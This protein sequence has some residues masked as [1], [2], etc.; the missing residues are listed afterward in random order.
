VRITV[1]S[2]LLTLTAFAAGAE[3]AAR[4]LGC[5]A[6]SSDSPVHA[7][8]QTAHGDLASGGQMCQACHGES[9]GH[10]GAPTEVPPTVSFGPHWPSP[11]PDQAGACLGCHEQNTASFWEGSVHSDEGLTCTSCH[12]IHSRFDTVRDRVSQTETCFGCH[13]TVQS[14]VH[15]Q[16]RHPILEGRTAC[17]DCH[18][19]H[20][21]VTPAALVEPTLNDTCYQ[22]HAEKRGPYL[23]EHAP[24]TEDCSLCHRPHGSV[25]PALLATR[26]PFLCQQCHAAAFHPSQLYDGQS[27]PGGQPSRYMLGNNCLNCHSQIHGSNHPSGAR[28]T[29]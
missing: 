18:D 2:L 29:R 16:S 12:D 25:N 10:Q 5:H 3:E 9:G 28:L 22:C 23:F 11:A 27:L 4:C 24:A 6:A 26:G 20:G 15:L 13:K 14:A 17:G 1:A 19:P 21:S 8:Y 7:I